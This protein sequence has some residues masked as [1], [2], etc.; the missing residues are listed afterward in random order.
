MNIK[1]KSLL[2]PAFLLLSFILISCG[3]DSSGPNDNRH[4]GDNSFTYEVEYSDDTYIV[5]KDKKNTLSKVDTIKVG[6]TDPVSGEDI[7]VNHY[8][9]TFD[10]TALADQF[11]NGSKIIIHGDYMAKVKSVSTNGSQVI[12]DTE[13]A[14]LKEVI[15]NGTIEWDITPE[16][17]QIETI[18]VEGKKIKANKMLDDGYEYEFEWLDR[19]YKLW[20]NPKGTSASG[21]PELQVNLTCQKIDKDNGRVTATLGAKGITRLP[22]QSTKIEISDNEMTTMNTG[23]K[24]LRSELT[25]EY[26]AEMTF[27]GTQVLTMPNIMLK[28][29]VS[30][31]TTLP[32]PIPMYITVGVG[33]ATTINMPVVSSFATAKVKLILDSDTG[34]EYEG[35]TVN[36][37]AKINDY[38]LGKAAWEIGAISLAPTP[39]EVRFDVSCPRVGL[40]LCDK[41]FAWVSGVFSCRNKL[42]VPSLCKAALYQVRIDGGYSFSILGYE[43]AE[44]SGAITEVSREE[45]SPECP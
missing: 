1:I 45:K 4:F 29:P 36:A 9:F 21:L 12:V 44:K 30:S 24:S 16:I 22:R 33:F 43:I 14:T 17:R 42:I 27:G 10:D 41:E 19:K 8:R 31:L 38:D 11:H 5:T 39:L 18:E 35:P 20:M 40:Q 37:S 34:F 7:Q 2:A 6:E 3:E 26:V 13:P 25:L 32:V 23:N 15:K 28:I